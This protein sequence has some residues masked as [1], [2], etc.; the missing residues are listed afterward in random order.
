[1]PD[2]THVA[3]PQHLREQHAVLPRSDYEHLGT[4]LGMLVAEK[5]EAYGDSFAKSGEILRVLYPSGVR[6][7]QYGDLLAIARVLDKLF[8]VATKKDAFGE[9]P[10]RDIA[11]YGLLGWAEDKNR[12][13]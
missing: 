9:T 10:W 7:D 4:K 6:P 2:S 11:G 12:D 13:R 5:N 1:M 3:I 8:R